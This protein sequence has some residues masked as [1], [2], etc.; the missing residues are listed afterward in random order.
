MGELRLA[1][2]FSGPSNSDGS[3][4]ASVVGC[5]LIGTLIGS[6][7]VSLGGFL[8][9]PLVGSLDGPL[10]TPI[11]VLVVFLNGLTDSLYR[12]PPRCHLSSSSQ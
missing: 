2:L 5:G 9:D 6:L 1:L 11:G 3:L 4:G 7:V 12:A 10:V 8:V